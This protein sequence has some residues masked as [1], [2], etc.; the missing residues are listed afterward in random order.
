MNFRPNRECAN[1]GRSIT[2][3]MR[4]S[5]VSLDCAETDCEQHMHIAAKKLTTSVRT[6]R[7]ILITIPQS[8]LLCRC[9]HLLSY[10]K[11]VPR[12]EVEALIVAVRAVY[13]RHEGELV[14]SCIQNRVF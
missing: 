1:S 7:F 4:C 3:L 10:R 5:S 8:N 12:V 14:K 11:N 6:A 13:G 2:F 9:T